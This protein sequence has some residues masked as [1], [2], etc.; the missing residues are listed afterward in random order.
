LVAVVLV[1]QPQ[2][3]QAVLTLCLAR[4]TLLAV[5]AVDLKS[6]GLNKVCQADLVAAAIAIQ[7]RAALEILRQHH[8]HKEIT[9]V[10]VLEVLLVAVVAEALA[11]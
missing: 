2:E 4:L 3:D 5:V 11:V 6:A 7:H 9:A 8:H 1:V 10:D